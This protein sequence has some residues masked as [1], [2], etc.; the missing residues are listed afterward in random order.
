MNTATSQNYQEALT[1]A[2]QLPPLERIAM[3]AELASSVAEN[4]APTDTSTLADDSFDPDEVAELMTV[5]PLSPHEIVKQGLLGTWSDFGIADG[6]EWVNTNKKT[7]RESR[8][9]QM[10][11]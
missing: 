7:R 5:D 11:S 4:A 8:K 1:L 2:L 6:A 9:W 3:I 10:P